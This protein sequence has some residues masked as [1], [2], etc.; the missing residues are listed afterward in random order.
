MATI[1]EATDALQ[2]HLGFDPARSRTISRQL[3]DN[4][5]LPAGAPGLAQQLSIDDFM[6]LLCAIAFDPLL[7]GAPDAARCADALTPGGAC[8]GV[9]LTMDGETAEYWPT[10]IPQSA[11]Q[12]LDIIAEMALGDRDSQRDVAAMR[13]EFVANWPE[14][15][16]YD[17]DR[18]RRFRERGS[19]AA[20]WGE[21][22][23]RR[24]TTINGSALVDAVR[25]L[26]K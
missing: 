9:D 17:G 3:I 23:H 7:R 21:R 5:L 26:F 15:A 13:L 1:R 6:T 8:L 16:I 19:N 12:A 24:S 25:S 14:I 18:I 4:G 22:G 20:H 11:R 2:Q 10:T